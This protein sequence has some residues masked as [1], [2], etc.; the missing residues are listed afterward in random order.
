MKKHIT[1]PIAL[2]I[3]LAAMAYFMHPSRHPGGE[4]D[5]VRYYITIGVTIVIIIALSYFLKRKEE[6]K[7][8]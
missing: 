5:F 6:N 7:K 1:V 3:Y 2:L 8:K 4:S